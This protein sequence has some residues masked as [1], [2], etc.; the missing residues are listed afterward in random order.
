MVGIPGSGKT[1][2]LSANLP[3]ATVVSMD[4]MRQV[5]LGDAADQSRNDEIFRRSMGALGAILKSGRSV[6]FD[7]TSV[8]WDRRGVP[9]RIARTHGAHVAMV[10]LDVSLDEARER[11]GRRARAVPDDVVVRMYR[12]LEAPAAGEADNA[13]LV[14]SGLAQPIH[15]RPGEEYLR[16][17][18]PAGPSILFEE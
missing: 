15:W 4:R 14:S 13:F 16:D 18:R 6:V 8:S 3:G 2:W 11:N 7:A 10:F 5:V 9:C 12:E 1:T 17:A